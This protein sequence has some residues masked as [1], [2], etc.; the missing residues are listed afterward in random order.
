M[1]WQLLAP[2]V[3]TERTPP[4]FVILGRRCA[5]IRP[6][7]FNLCVCAPNVYPVAPVVGIAALPSNK[8]SRTHR[9]LYQ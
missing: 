9:P 7:S 4:F 8:H 5:A 6:V 1:F 3:F 2:C